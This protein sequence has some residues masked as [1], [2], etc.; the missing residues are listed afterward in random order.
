MR[1]RTIGYGLAIGTFLLGACG[2]DD[3]SGTGGSAGG[4][5]IPFDQVLGMIVDLQCNAI[6]T[7]AG[8]AFAIY[9]N[10]MTCETYFGNRFEDGDWPNIKK[11]IDEGRVKYDGKKAQACFDAWAAQGCD[12]F[13]SRAPEICDQTLEGTVAEGGDCTLNM[14]CAGPLFCRVDTACPGKCTARMPG[15]S[16]CKDSDECQDGFTC[17]DTLKKCVVPAK[18]GE[19]C[20]T[21]KPDCILGLFCQGATDTESGACKEIS[22]VLV[23][24]DGDA[25]GFE[26]ASW[27]KDGLSCV[28]ESWTQDGAQ[29][30]C[31]PKVNAGDTCGIG[32]PNQCPPDYQCDANPAGGTW[33][34]KCAPMPTDGEPCLTVEG[35]QQCANYHVCDTATKNCKA[36][37][38]LDG[39]CSADNQCYSENCAGGKCAATDACTQ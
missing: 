17:D 29:A 25:C 16:N 26:T 22:E 27:C 24:N 35:L 13:S 3:D 2:G 23:N 9:L 20:Q 4:T 18:K 34:G 10:G 7:C 12:I 1:M 19:A 8:D 39:A 21:G 36:V 14:E 38:R 28:V 11:A 37:Q 5:I 31:K 32:L 15:G 6:Q 33:E 30:K